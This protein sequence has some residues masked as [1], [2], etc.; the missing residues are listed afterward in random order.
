MF[1]KN[2][3]VVP[4]RKGYGDA[5]EKL[6]EVN[7]N[8]VVLCADLTDS[9]QCAKFAEK[10]PERFIECGVAEQNM[11]AIAAGLGVSGKIPFISSYATFSPGK[12]WETIRT[13]IVYNQSNVKIAGHHSGI[14]T[15][16]DGATHQATEDIAS[17]R[18]W[19]LIKIVI[20]CDSN[21]AFRATEASVDIEGPIYLRFT[22]DKTPVITTDKTPFD[23][24]HAQI[25]WLGKNPQ[26]TIFGTGHLLYYA[27]VAASELEREKI[28][29]DVVNVATIKPIDEVTIVSSA[30]KSGAVVTVEDHQITGG[31]GSAIAE[32]LSRNKPL[33]MEYIGLQDTFAES[34]K[35]AELIKKYKMDDE[36]IIEAVKKVIKRK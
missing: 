19:P 35:P 32:V 2:V 27:L 25:Y 33:P 6:G 8:I 31:L 36:A 15:G 28:D 16:P 18:A 29:V 24:N 4:T 20:P 13:T 30:E 12:N 17:V 5:L 10:F 14:V 26:A 3:E 22:R 23:I 1:D 7:P 11:A 21:E 34:G 9:T